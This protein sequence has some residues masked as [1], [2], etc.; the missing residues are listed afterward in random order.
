MNLHTREERSH[1]PI[2][3]AP[4]NHEGRALSPESPLTLG[5]AWGQPFLGSL[6]W[7]PACASTAHLHGHSPF[8][9]TLTELLSPFTQNHQCIHMGRPSEPRSSGAKQRFCSQSPNWFVLL[10]KTTQENVGLV[11]PSPMLIPAPRWSTAL[12]VLVPHILS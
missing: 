9:L 4:G 1:N 8:S 5:P 12:T 7:V 10:P 11:S 2:S 6:S 3:P